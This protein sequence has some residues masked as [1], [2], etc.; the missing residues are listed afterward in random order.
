MDR[1]GHLEIFETAL[2]DHLNFRGWQGSVQSGGTYHINVPKSLKTITG[3]WRGR[4]WKTLA[5][6]EKVRFHQVMKH[7]RNGL[8]WYA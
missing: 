5:V 2:Q 3:L 6:G 7:K 8:F 1:I 4:C